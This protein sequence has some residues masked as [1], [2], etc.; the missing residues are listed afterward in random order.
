MH[1][2]T[3]S[4]PVLIISGQFNSQN[5]EGFRLIA[6]EKELTDQQLLKIIPALTYEDGYKVFSSRTD[7]GCVIVDWDIPQESTEEKMKPFDMVN[8]M[9]KRRTDIPILLLTDHLDTG[10]IPAKTLESINGCVWKTSDTS[11]FLAGRIKRHVLQYIKK[12]LPPFFGELVKYSNEF[13]YAWHTPGHMGGEGFLRSPAGTAL[14]KFYGENVLRSAFPFQCRN[15]V[16][17]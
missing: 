11:Q 16:R 17:Y 4:W 7:L 9:R 6:L 5:Y 14:F 3:I 13:K 15:L 1:S 10:N 2:T 8:L 12:V